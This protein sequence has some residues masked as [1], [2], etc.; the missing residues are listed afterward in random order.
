MGPTLLVYLVDHL[1][2]CIADDFFFNFV[3]R[4]FF[5]L[6]LLNALVLFHFVFCAKQAI[7]VGW[8]VLLLGSHA[9]ELLKHHCIRHEHVGLRRTRLLLGRTA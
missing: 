6:R 2:D 3:M 5:L 9:D 4:G 7:V 8:R 1:L